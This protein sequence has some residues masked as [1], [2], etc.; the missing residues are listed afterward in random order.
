MPI[1]KGT[2][3]PSSSMSIIET[4]PSYSLLMPTFQ[5]VPSPIIQVVW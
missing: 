2:H 5:Q 4:G 3:L 1:S